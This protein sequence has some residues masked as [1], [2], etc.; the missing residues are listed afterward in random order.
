MASLH[1]DRTLRQYVFLSLFSLKGIKKGFCFILF[2][3]M[4]ISYYHFS[5]KQWKNIFPELFYLLD[6]IFTS[7]EQLI[8][9]QTS[10]TVFASDLVNLTAL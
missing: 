4:T 10:V 2:Q 3:L 9:F 7:V 1:S 5:Q 6:W 8:I